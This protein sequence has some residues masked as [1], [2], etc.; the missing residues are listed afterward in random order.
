MHRRQIKTSVTATTQILA[1]FADA[2]GRPVRQ[3]LPVVIVVLIPLRER[4]DHFTD[5]NCDNLVGRGRRRVR[6]RPWIASC[7]VGGL[8]GEASMDRPVTR[9]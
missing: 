7:S 8:C 2:V 4:G 9:E 5:L 3:F 6:V 1:D